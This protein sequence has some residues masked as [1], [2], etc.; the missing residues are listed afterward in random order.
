MRREGDVAHTSGKRNSY[1]ILIGKPEE[2]GLGRQKRKLQRIVIL[3]RVRITIVTV[4][5]Q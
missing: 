1:R 4:E 2:K 5:K 3:R